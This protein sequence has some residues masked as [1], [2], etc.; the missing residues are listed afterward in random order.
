MP[1]ALPILGLIAGAVLSS[2]LAP[3]PPD[4]PSPAPIPPPPAAAPIPPPP[5]APTGSESGITPEDAAAM[6]AQESARRRR[7][8]LSSTDLS[9]TTTDPNA[10]V[11]TKSLL[12]E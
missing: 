9:Q 2:A 8:A 1:A 7:A 10:S 11:Q 4:A 6:A 3:S 12:G 5:A